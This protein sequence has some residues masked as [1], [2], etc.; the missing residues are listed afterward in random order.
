MDSKVKPI[1]RFKFKF[2]DSNEKEKNIKEKKKTPCTGPPLPSSA[3]ALLLYRAVSPAT[4]QIHRQAGP[5]RQSRTLASPYTSLIREA[6]PSAAPGLWRVAQDCQ[7]NPTCHPSA[8]STNRAP[9]VDPPL[10]SRVQATSPPP[11]TQ[12][13]KVELAHDFPS[14]SPSRA[15][16]SLPSHPSLR[17][18]EQ[19]TSRRR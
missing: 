9:C 1:T 14:S 10:S 2:E 6:L 12:T 4:A 16:S 5:L 7:A 15:L 11:W 18:R 17:E 3:H 13:I 8:A 19:G